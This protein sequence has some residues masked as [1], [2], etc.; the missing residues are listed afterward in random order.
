MSQRFSVVLVWCHEGQSSD[1][2]GLTFAGR[3]AARS[4]A[5]SFELSLSLSSAFPGTSQGPGNTRRMHNGKQSCAL[6]FGMLIKTL[7]QILRGTRVMGDMFV[8]LM[9]MQQID[10]LHSRFSSSAALSDR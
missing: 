4:S 10:C 2:R 7:H 3:T 9:K 8:A 6:P 1:A 5:L